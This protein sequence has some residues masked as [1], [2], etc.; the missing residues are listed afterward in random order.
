MIFNDFH[1]GA[2]AIKRCPYG[3]MRTIDKERFAVFIVEVHLK[4]RLN[5]SP[6]VWVKFNV[7]L[8]KVLATR[9]TALHEMMFCR[10][11][12]VLLDFVF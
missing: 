3:D 12:K 2:T 9:Y 8:H 6:E 10:E 4:F 5:P 7:Q 11:N 1:L